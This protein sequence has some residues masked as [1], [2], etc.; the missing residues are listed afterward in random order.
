[1][2]QT[3]HALNLGDAG[4][5]AALPDASVQL[6][7]TSPPYPMI[8][9]W[10]AGFCETA[11][12]VRALLAAGKGM[13]AFEAMHLALDQVWAACSRVLVPGGF[14]CINIGDATRTLSPETGE[15]GEFCLYPNHARI[16]TAM[17]RLGLTPL[18]DILWRKPN[19]SPNKFMGSGMLPAGA[20]VTYEHEYILIFRKGGKR[21]FDEAQK[22]AR[23]RSA[24]FWEERNVWFSDIW[25]D[26]KGA[27]QRLRHSPAASSGAGG[28]ELRERSGAFP[29][30][31]PFR[32]V[33]MYS[34]Q[35]DTVLDP[36]AGT[37]TTMAAALAAGRSSVGFE[38]EAGLGP[39]VADT[40]AAAIQAGRDRV[41]AR[42]NEHERFIAARLELGKEHK[43]VSRHYGFPVVT[44]Q[45]VEMQL[46]VPIAAA[47]TPAGDPAAG[48]TTV[49]VEHG[50]LRPSAGA[51][52]A[53]RPS[54]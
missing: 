32:L 25:T 48:G 28:E 43:H 7:V 44:R 41:A 26:L 18:P 17:L 4:A 24:F 34:L 38:R 42:L 1:M 49:T 29:F 2:L 30:E 31:L 22:A 40:L 23:S 33:N 12:G 19:N 35:G 27:S 20:Y 46:A 8:A 54:A 50:F 6:V 51:L 37:G 45:E 13:D 5:M 16:I 3:M 53:P 14:V 11:P 39:V 47:Q 21:Q 36:F 10:D 9:M 52:F 15:G